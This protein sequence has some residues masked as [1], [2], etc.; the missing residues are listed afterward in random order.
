MF[1][2]ILK[3]GFI[4]IFLATGLI[5]IL[6][7]PSGWLKI[8]EWYRKKIF[9]ALILEVI[10]AV[11]ILFDQEIISNGPKES[12]RI[13]IS[14]DEWV[15]LND[16]GLIVRPVFNVSIQD[17]SIKQKYGNKSYK[18]FKGL[19]GEI[20][21]KGFSIRNSTNN[22]LATITTSELEQNG[23]FNSF[24][25]A[26]EE[27]TSSENYSYIKWTKKLNGEW[28][29]K[30]EFIG[31]FELKVVDSSEGTFY[32][33]IDNIKDTIVYKSSERSKDMISEDNRIVH[34]FECENLYYLITITW[35]DLLQNEKYVHVV[36]IRLH[37]T[38]KTNLTT[39]N[40]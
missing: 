22:S 40:N 21:Q 2:E 16:S 19:S 26:K 4:V 10:G 32:K 23:I 15:G 20:S 7:L 6:S 12:P 35:A 29:K 27:I 33:I 8:D 39:A 37:P 34:F 11:I 25:T 30:G 28:R 3:Y 31:P 14:E 17:I 38:F 9:I 36:N 24:K 1:I 18:E 13:S 5:G